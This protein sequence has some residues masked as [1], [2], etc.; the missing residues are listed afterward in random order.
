MTRREDRRCA[1]DDCL[2][3]AAD[4]ETHDRSRRG[5]G[6]ARARRWAGPL[7]H[8]VDDVDSVGGDFRRV[9]ALYLV[10]VSLVQIFLSRLLD[11]DGLWLP[12]R[13]RDYNEGVRRRRRDGEELRS[14]MRRRG[15][16][17]QA[18]NACHVQIKR[19]WMETK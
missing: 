7:R 3:E 16:G 12:Q 1:G 19:I 2:N 8:C 13:K 17:A 11:N 15:E 14:G 10:F 4:A 18:R 5:G 9:I 6:R